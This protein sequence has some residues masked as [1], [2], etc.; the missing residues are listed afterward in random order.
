M[1]LSDRDIKKL[2]EE[3]K[4]KISPEPNWE[5]Q[6]SPASV[7]FR[8]G[9]EFRVF[10]HSSISHI[11]PKDKNTFYNLTKSIKENPF[12]L[13]PGEF[14]LGVT[15]E[16]IELPEDIGARI[17]GRS[18]WG[19]LGIIVHS[20]AGYIDPGFKGNL[21]LEISN[22]GMLPVLLYPGMRF[23]QIAFEKLSSPAKRSYSQK[24]DMKYFGDKGPQES[25]IHKDF[26][27]KD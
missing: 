13:Q 27:E 4:I 1:L 9:E 2:F 22:I 18:S 14:I 24:T 5:I 6:L 8:L 25:K 11:D 10:N 19:R 21:T 26:E 20:T 12:V 3:E 23:C 7:D 15:L 17:E 16:E